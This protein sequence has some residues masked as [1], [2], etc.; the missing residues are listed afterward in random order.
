M[1]MSG[2]VWFVGNQN[3]HRKYHKWVE[4]NTWKNIIL[5]ISKPY[6]V[7]LIMI[8]TQ[9]NKYKTNNSNKM[10]SDYILQFLCLFL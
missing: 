6:I 5:A 7:I 1:Q 3:N 9:T 10:I 2:Y 8:Q 4:Y